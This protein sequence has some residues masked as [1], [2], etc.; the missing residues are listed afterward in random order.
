MLAI[1]AAVLAA[2]A[3]GRAP[4]DCPSGRRIATSREGYLLRHGTELYA[5]ARRA[6]RAWFIAMNELKEAWGHAVLH[7]SKAAVAISVAF[8]PGSHGV[9]VL[10]IRARRQCLFE[11]AGTGGSDESSGSPVRRLLV[12]R[13]GAVAY[14]AG[15]AAGPVPAESFPTIAPWSG[16]E[17]IVSDGA[18]RRQ[19]AAGRDIDPRSLRIA[20]STVSW[21]SGGVAANAPIG[22]GKPCTEPLTPPQGRAKP[23]P[24]S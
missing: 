12:S 10:D 21:R 19:V 2:P 24:Y 7:G 11:L 13:T 3:H 4:Y 18:G 5:C 16:Y 23:T 1:A 6:S 22:P 8:T 17:V 14:V 20:G 15:P 9:Q